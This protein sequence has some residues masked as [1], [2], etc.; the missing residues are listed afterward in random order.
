MQFPMICICCQ[1]LDI[2]D[3]SSSPYTK[4]HTTLLVHVTKREGAARTVTNL[5]RGLQRLMGWVLLLRS[6]TVH[7]LWLQLF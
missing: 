5:Y 6:L 2:N 7:A 3:L 1:V 4:L